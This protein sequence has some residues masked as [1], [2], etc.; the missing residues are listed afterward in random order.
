MEQR[1]YRG[2]DGTEVSDGG[3]NGI[4]AVEEETDEPGSDEATPAG[5][6]DG[7]FDG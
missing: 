3:M 5:N 7:S 6:A 1:D 4:A 2:R